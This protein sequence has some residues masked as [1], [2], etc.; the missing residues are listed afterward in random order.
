MLSLSLVMPKIH[1]LLLWITFLIF[2]PF[3]YSLCWTLC[4]SPR[5]PPQ[6]LL[7]AELL[8]PDSPQR[9]IPT[10]PTNR[11]G[12]K[13][14]GLYQ[15]PALWLLP[16]SCLYPLTAH[17]GALRL[18]LGTILQDKPSSRASHGICGVICGT[19]SQHSPSSPSAQSCFFPISVYPESMSNILPAPKA[20]SSSVS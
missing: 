2:S 6:S 15:G 14:D 12:L 3:Y 11:S 9:S 17:W 16:Q 10:P 4:I 20:I 7:A 8:T 5:P 13:W 19:A 1:M 18:R